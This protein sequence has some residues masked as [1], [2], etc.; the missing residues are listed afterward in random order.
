MFLREIGEVSVV[1]GVG[2]HVV[3]VVVLAFFRILERREGFD[4]AAGQ[5]VAVDHGEA[6]VLRPDFPVHIAALRSGHVD[7]RHVL[8]VFGGRMQ[9]LKFLGLAVELRH[10][11]PGRSCRTRDCRRDPVCRPSSPVGQPGF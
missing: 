3:D 6:V 8:V 7:L 11:P 9:D 10:G 5:I 2:N 4:L 1:L